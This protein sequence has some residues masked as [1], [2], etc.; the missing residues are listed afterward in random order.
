[1][2]FSKNPCR[3][4]TFLET[5]QLSM[6]L[7]PK[8]RPWARRRKLNFQLVSLTSRHIIC[9]RFHPLILLL[10]VSE[11]VTSLFPET[12]VLVQLMS[13]TKDISSSIIVQIAE[14]W[15]SGI[16]LKTNRYARFVVK[17]LSLETCRPLWTRMHWLRTSPSK[18]WCTTYRGVNRLQ[19]F[20][21][22]KKNTT[23]NEIVIDEKK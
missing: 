4:S 2:A 23:I 9:L 19:S 8:I 14:N 20:P 21:F 5:L 18:G 12:N 17:Q 1:M 3:M 22:W 15:L 6:P 7:A 13:R 10:R 11:I 16:N